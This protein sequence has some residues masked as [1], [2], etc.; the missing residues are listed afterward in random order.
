MRSYQHKHRYIPRGRG[1]YFRTQE[2][3]LQSID[4]YDDIEKALGTYDPLAGAWVRINPLDGKGIRNEN[5]SEYRYTLVES[6]E[7]SLQQ[8]LSWIRSLRLPT[9]ALVHNAGNSIRT[10]FFIDTGHNRNQ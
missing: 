9:V 2:D 3:I 4:T 10:V 8:Q 7:L 1:I 6:D 5:V